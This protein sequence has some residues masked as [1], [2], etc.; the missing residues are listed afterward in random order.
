MATMDDSFIYAGTLRGEEYIRKIGRLWGLTGVDLTYLDKLEVYGDS[1]GR[2]VKV[3]TGRALDDGY[4]G[5]ITVEKTIA[6]ATNTSGNPRID[7]IVVQTVPG[8]PMTIEPV[9]GTPA[10]SPTAPALTQSAT[11]T[12]QFS[13]AQVAVADAYTT[14]AAGDVTDER[15]SC[16]PQLYVSKLASL[17][18]SSTNPF[19]LNGSSPAGMTIPIKP[20][21]Y[22]LSA[23]LHVTGIMDTSGDEFDVLIRDGLTAGSGTVHGRVRV[24]ASST[25]Q[26]AAVSVSEIT[27]DISAGTPTVLTVSP[28]TAK[29][30]HAEVV[31]VSGSGTFQTESAAEYGLLSATVMPL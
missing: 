25:N 14:V 15:P 22:Q 7:R 6:L 18:T 28:G 17:T 8:G 12:F 24:R 16:K 19:N 5:E 27:A 9:Q 30:M 29:T 23:R 20:Y 2:Q 13:L 11:G 4:Y 3:K 31:R 21:I 1:T 10:G 26:R